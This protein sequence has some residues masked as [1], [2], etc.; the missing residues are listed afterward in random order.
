MKRLISI[1]VVVAMMFSLVA[2]A[3]PV[4]ATEGEGEEAT[5]S[6]VAPETPAVSKND[7]GASYVMPAGSWLAQAK[8]FAGALVGLDA[9]GLEAFE[10]VSD[11]LTTAGCTMKNTTAGY[12]VT[13]I[14][15]LS[16]VR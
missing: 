13:F 7:Q 5:Y 10:V 2:S 1:L 11:A 3:L 6:I 16:Y 4:F 9:A 14:A 8:A 12:K 15:A